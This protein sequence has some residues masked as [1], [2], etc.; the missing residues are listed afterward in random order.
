MALMLGLVMWGVKPALNLGGD[1]GTVGAMEDP[2]GP[3]KP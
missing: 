1:N 2:Y 3:P